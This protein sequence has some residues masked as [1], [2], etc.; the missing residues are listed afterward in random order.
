M[1]RTVTKIYS[2]WVWSV[3]LGNFIAGRFFWLPMKV[4]GDYPLCNIM[5]RESFL[6]LLDSEPTRAFAPASLTNRITVKLGWHNKPQLYGICE[7]FSFLNSF[8]VLS[9]NRGDDAT[10]IVAK[11]IPAW[12]LMTALIK[13]KHHPHLCLKSSS[14][15]CSADISPAIWNQV[16]QLNEPSVDKL[17]QRKKMNTSM[18][19]V[20][21]YTCR[22]A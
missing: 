14:C 13:S 1:T 9:V 2:C 21:V 17:F 18:F 22:A 5:W 3:P 6:L 8:M 12:P 11:Q 20:T 16:L 7:S 10:L 19:K 15:Q 4:T